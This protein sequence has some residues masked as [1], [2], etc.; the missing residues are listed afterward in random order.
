MEIIGDIQ[1]KII[2]NRQPLQEHEDE[3]VED[4]NPDAVVKYIEATSGAKFGINI[5]VP[6]SYRFS[7]DALLFEISLDGSYVTSEILPR[8]PRPWD[9][10]FSGLETPN[11]DEH[12]LRPF[13]F[14][15]IKA[16]EE[17]SIHMGRL[18]Q[19]TLDAIGI[20][21]VKAFR[22]TRTYGR[23]GNARHPNPKGLGQITEIA[24]KQLKGANVTHTAKLGE[25]QKCNPRAPSEVDYTD[26]GDS[27]IASFEFKYCSR[28]ALQAM[29]LIPRTPSPVP[30]ELRPVE[31]W[32][33]EELRET[34]R[35][36]VAARAESESRPQVK[37]ELKVEPA[38]GVKRECDEEY[39][40]IMRSARVKKSKANTPIVDEEIIDLCSDD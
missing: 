26:D 18:Q 14:S 39:D 10:T 12:Y 15:E 1:A 20:I 11:A 4:E 25:K 17:G 21:T 9:V 40:E 31:E 28:K 36:H 6:M 27:P 32:T 23:V 13:M 19:D 30:L 8:R 37:P 16:L 5:I 34:A 35:N 38:R 24:E 29:L 3:E 2:V 22:A 33:L 7:S